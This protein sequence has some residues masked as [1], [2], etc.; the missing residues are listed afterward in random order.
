MKKITSLIVAL[1]LLILF[2]S[3]Q[4]QALSCAQLLS[5]EEAYAKYDGVIVGKVDKVV[6]NGVHNIVKSTVTTSFKGVSANKVSIGEDGFWGNLNGPSKV[7]K[8]YL[9]F[10]T[11]KNGKWE[12]PLCSPSK[13]VG[14][15]TEELAFLQG[16]EIPLPSIPDE[17]ESK[18]SQAS[19]WIISAIA[20]LVLG[21][22]AYVYLRTR[23]K[24]PSK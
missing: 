19:I 18:A 6:P 20:A 3:P 10:L 5:V 21:I 8:Q 23:R 15:A 7:G 17:N 13:L 4:A 2:Y 9:F 16:K 1:L 22:L 11:E 12:N 14:E 24:T